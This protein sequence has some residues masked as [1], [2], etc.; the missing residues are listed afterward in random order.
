MAKIPITDVRP[1]KHLPFNSEEHY[2]HKLGVCL[3]PVYFATDY[4]LFIQF[5][6][7]WLSQG[8]TKFYIYWES[9]SPEVQDILQFY[10][11]TSGADIELVRWS[12]LP[13]IKGKRGDLETNPNSYWF[14]LEV[15]LAIFDCMHRAR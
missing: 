12:E 7:Y 10:I 4:T 8:A 2:P 11:E 9:F 14:R 3:Q 5:F 13:I 15:F 6:E 1:Q